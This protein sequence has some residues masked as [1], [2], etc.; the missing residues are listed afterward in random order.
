MEIKRTLLPTS[1]TYSGESFS[2]DAKIPILL[3]NNG[4]SNEKFPD[5]RRFMFRDDDDAS[6]SS[7]LPLGVSGFPSPQQ[8]QQ[9]SAHADHLARAQRM[10]EVSRERP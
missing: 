2:S 3:E 5:D 10:T 9:R 7:V 1:I 6:S 4:G 8:S